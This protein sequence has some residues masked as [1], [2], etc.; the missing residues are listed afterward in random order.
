MVGKD[1]E[2]PIV[3]GGWVACDMDSYGLPGQDIGHSLN[4]PRIN[5]GVDKGLLALVNALLKPWGYSV[6]EDRE[7]IDKNLCRQQGSCGGG[8]FPTFR[9]NQAGLATINMHNHGRID[10]PTERET[11]EVVSEEAISLFTI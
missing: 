5:G 8:F 3:V 11:A 7:G 9:P 10:S 1:E 4:S 2:E 6:D